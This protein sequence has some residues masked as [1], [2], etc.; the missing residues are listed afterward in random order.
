MPGAKQSP[1]QFTRLEDYTHGVLF[2]APGLAA[3]TNKAVFER[4]LNAEWVSDIEG[5]M[6]TIHPE[7]PFQRIPA[8]GVDVLGF[9]GV[10]RFYEGRFAS[11][12]GP[13]LKHFDRV[14]VTDSCIYV[15]G[16][17]EIETRGHFEG[18]RASGRH[19]SAPVVIVLEFR[20]GLLAGETVYM[21]SA[22]VKG[23]AA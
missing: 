16:R 1:T 10:R 8:L 5:T 21:D 18:L 13:A 23:E 2:V 20:D 15:E 9:E 22:V 4:H 19:I 11:W 6:A 17:M 14:A 12:P 3:K 7:A